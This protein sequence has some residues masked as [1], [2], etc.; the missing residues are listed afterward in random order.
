MPYYIIEI[1]Y[2]GIN[3]DQHIDSDEIQIRTE[4]GRTNSS[5]EVSTEGWLGTT[6]DWAY[7][8]HGEYETI[9]EAREAVAEKF[10]NVRDSDPD[11]ADEEWVVE[12]YKP[13][14]YAPMDAEATRNWVWEGVRCDITPDTTDEQIQALLDDYESAANSD[15]YTLDTRTAEQM[16][17]DYR[18]EQV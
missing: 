3:Q 12:V 5:N 11:Y 4:P 8:A 18:E 14:K 1:N 6:N 16:M 7:Y 9:D 13:G 17:Y 10:D 15:G 2:V